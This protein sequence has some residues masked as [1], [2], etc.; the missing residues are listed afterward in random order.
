MHCR[1]TSSRK[2]LPCNYEYDQLE[3]VGDVGDMGD[4]ATSKTWDIIKLP[5]QRAMN[6]ITKEDMPYTLLQHWN[7]NYVLYAKVYQVHRKVG[8][9]WTVVLS[10]PSLNFPGACEI[11][12]GMHH[13]WLPNKG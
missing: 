3:C 6:S 1:A 12:A 8:I 2:N 4:L 5:E 11:Q 9:L 13:K 10:L 7:Y